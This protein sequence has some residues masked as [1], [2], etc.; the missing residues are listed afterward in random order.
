MWAN[1][2]GRV[3]QKRLLKKPAMIF[4]K[5]ALEPDS[6]NKSIDYDKDMINKAK[7]AVLNFG[8]VS[9]SYLMRKLKCDSSTADRIMNEIG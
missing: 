8:Q 7:S 2:P 1:E 3:H 5:L 4:E 9:T 6:T